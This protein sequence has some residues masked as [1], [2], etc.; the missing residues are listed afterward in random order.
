MPR[1]KPQNLKVHISPK[2][3]HKVE[4]ESMVYEVW[5]G[6][7]VEAIAVAKFP[8]TLKTLSF[9]EGVASN[10]EVRGFSV[11]NNVIPP[12][13]ADERGFCLWSVAGT[14]V[15]AGGSIMVMAKNITDRPRPFCFRIL[16]E[17]LDEDHVYAPKAV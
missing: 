16:M 5:A 2:V 9:M 17:V 7:E 6:A 15:R 1:M 13:T 12:T 10:F 3:F 14:V 4:C 8:G 11:N